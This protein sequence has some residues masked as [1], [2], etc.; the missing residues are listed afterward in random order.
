MAAGLL[1]NIVNVKKT[2]ERFHEMEKEYNLFS[3]RSKYNHPVWDICRYNIYNEINLKS[4]IKSNDNI[5]SQTNQR[6][7]S[8]FKSFLYLLKSIKS[9]NKSVFFTASRESNV[10]GK[11]FDRNAIDAINLLFP[12]VFIVE[13]IKS[14]KNLIYS[15]FTYSYDGILNSFFN[16][17]LKKSHPISQPINKIIY[18]AL[19]EYFREFHFSSETI[20]DVYKKFLFSYYYYLVLLRLIHPK[21]IF[22]TQNGIQ[23]GLILAARS[24]KIPIFEFQ[25]GLIDKSH[26]AYSYNKMINFHKNDIILPDKVLFYSDYWANKIYIPFV[27]K[28]VIGNSILTTAICFKDENII[29]IISADI[30]SNW[31]KDLTRKLALLFRN[32]T[33][34]YKLHSNEYGGLSSYIEF[35]IDLPNVSVIK[36][37]ISILN[38][39]SFSK[40]FILIE[41]TVVYEVLQHGRPV[42]LYNKPGSEIHDDILNSSLVFRADTAVEMY[43]I[44]SRL[45]IPKYQPISFFKNFDKKVFQSI[46]DNFE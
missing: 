45:I 28:Q 30:Y 33:F 12:E 20:V 25:H 44:I 6:G 17:F 31:L 39:I 15:D 34:Y 9:F 41:S 3:L 24:H 37:E 42:C 38:L 8:K 16:F 1:S 27:D 19:N 26:M 10:E 40:I 22:L 46:I 32:T 35:F 11:L 29:T 18:N 36:N 5:V 43:N 14:N 13:T 7:R 23:K 4:N 2:Y 21:R